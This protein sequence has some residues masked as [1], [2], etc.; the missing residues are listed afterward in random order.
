MRPALRL[1]LL[2]F[3]IETLFLSFW[4]LDDRFN[5]FHLPSVEQAASI[6]NYSQ[7]ALRAWIE[8]ANCLLCPPVIATSFAGMDLGR[9]A[10]I[11]LVLIAAVL[12]AALYF[13]VGLAVTGIRS[14]IRVK[15]ARS[16]S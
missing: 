3:L 15:S 6:R 10:N 9:T 7:P 11:V 8:D 4:L 14:R 5:F 16:P 2:G 12:N 1:A 13:L